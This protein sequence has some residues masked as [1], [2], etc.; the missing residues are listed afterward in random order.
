VFGWLVDAGR[1]EAMFMIAG[2]CLIGIGLATALAPPSGGGSS[3]SF[4]N[5][6]T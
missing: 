4:I 3:S 5:R 2:A 6:D 1:Y